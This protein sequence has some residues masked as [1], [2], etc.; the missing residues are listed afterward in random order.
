MYIYIYLCRYNNFKKTV[1]GYIL[2]CLSCELYMIIMNGTMY[3]IISIKK[4]N[5]LIIIF[6]SW[7]N[8]G[9]MR[10]ILIIINYYKSSHWHFCQS[11]INNSIKRNSGEISLELNLYSTKK[12]IQFVN[13][14][15]SVLLFQNEKISLNSSLLE[16]QNTINRSFSEQFSSQE[17]FMTNTVSLFFNIA[18]NWKS[19]FTPISL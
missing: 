10:K 5:Y 4:V 12:Y 8:L 15:K 9:I 17:R 1:Y 3:C 16:P 2:H 6:Q 11:C 14:S 18:F 7:R 13:P 19:V